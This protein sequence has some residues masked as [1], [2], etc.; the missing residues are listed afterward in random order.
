MLKKNNWLQNAVIAMLVLIV[1]LC[2]NMG[3][4]TKVQAGGLVCAILNNKKFR[5]W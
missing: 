1:G 4:G 5:K 2:I 3:S